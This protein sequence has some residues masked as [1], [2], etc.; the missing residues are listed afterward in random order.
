MNGGEPEGRRR[1][2]T[3]TQTQRTCKACVRN[4]SWAVGAC[5][6]RS[7]SLTGSMAAAAAAAAAAACVYESW[8]L[9]LLRLLLLLTLDYLSVCVAQGVEANTQWRSKQ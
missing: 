3:Q 9:L 6:V 5:A 8:V 2:D 4:G 7:A 1:I